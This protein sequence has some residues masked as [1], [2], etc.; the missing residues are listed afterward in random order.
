[1]LTNVHFRQSGPDWMQVNIF[2]NK[3]NEMKCKR[4]RKNPSNDQY[5]QKHSCLLNENLGKI[6][7]ILFSKLSQ[8]SSSF[9]KHQLV[10]I[11]PFI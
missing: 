7:L 2:N 9:P 8:S 1:M 4:S 10:N 5:K 11:S 3:I 6:S